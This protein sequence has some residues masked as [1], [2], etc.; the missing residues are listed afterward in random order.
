MANFEESLQSMRSFLV[1]CLIGSFFSVAH[2]DLNK[3]LLHHI[4]WVQKNMGGADRC[5]DSPP[6]SSVQNNDV[7]ELC[8]TQVCGTSDKV[9]NSDELAVELIKDPEFHK[10]VAQTMMEAMAGINSLLDEAG[11]E[12]LLSIE[13]FNDLKKKNDLNP[14]SSYLRL[15]DLTAMLTELRRSSFEAG[16]SQQLPIVV[17]R[18]STLA[19]LT[20]LPEDQRK[21]AVDSV[22]HFIRSPIGSEFM[23]QN[24]TQPRD[25][26]RLKY[27][28]LSFKD[29]LKAEG[30]V[31]QKLASNLLNGPSGS[32]VRMIAGASKTLTDPTISK[33]VN[34]EDM[35]DTEVS[36]FM[37]VRASA[38]LFNDVLT[39]KEQGGQTLLL[40]T[41]SKESLASFVARKNFDQKLSQYQSDLR[42]PQKVQEKRNA[43]YQSCY[44]NYIFQMATLPTNAQIEASE[45]NGVWAK[46][47][48]KEILGPVLSVHTKQMLD[49]VI[50][51]SFFSMPRSKES[52]HK[53]FMEKIRASTSNSANVAR[54]YRTLIDNGQHKP[55]TLLNIHLNSDDY[56][57]DKHFHD[58]QNFC[59][60]FKIKLTSDNAMTSTGGIE[61]SWVSARKPELGKAVMLHELGHLAFRSLDSEK[62]SAESRA[63]FQGIKKCLSDNH[64]EGAS[65]GHYADEDW[66]D[67]IAGKGAGREN[68]NIGCELSDQENDKYINLILN[69]SKSNDEH[70]TDF[71][72]ALHFHKIQNGKLPSACNQFIE[73]QGSSWKFNS[74]L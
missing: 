21:W 16:P 66:S 65:T 4:E 26:L 57:L 35:T 25:F 73:S 17:N 58:A 59:D 18:E 49:G 27:P 13:G 71:F 33:A 69:D 15:H 7:A 22:D 68:S 32:I 47:R 67:L 45:K 14:T 8:M 39:A 24:T 38:P 9:K 60:N 50:D 54:E 51:K 34:G 61:T 53:Y 52:F 28:N 43:T 5:V 29:A 74:C 70:S 63:H 72:R 10:S 62:A 37:T 6:T 46:G 42:D 41:S 1:T 44:T 3:G 30:L 55:L 40:P 36:E 2:A 23:L 20:D 11:K 56:S 48:I 19:K 64:P 31:T 12:K